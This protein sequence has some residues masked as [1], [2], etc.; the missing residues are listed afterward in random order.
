M[1]FLCRQKY[2][3][4]L[5]VFFSLAGIGHKSSLKEKKN[6]VF[7]VS[8]SKQATIFLTTNN[9]S[10]LPIRYLNQHQHN[11]ILPVPVHFQHTHTF[12]IPQEHDI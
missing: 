12:P 3:L 4:F 10:L 7:D 5:L 9:T 1:I 11:V 8:V 2:Y 6:P